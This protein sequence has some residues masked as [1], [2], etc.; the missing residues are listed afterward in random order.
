M[1]LFL[2][3]SPCDND[4]PAHM[5]L[6]CCYFTRN[7]FV[8]NLKKYWKQNSRCVIIAAN[9][10]NYEKSEEMVFTFRRCF[11]Y[12]GMIPETFVLLDSRNE[13]QAEELIKNSDFVML[14]GGHVPTERAFFERIG[15]REIMKNYDGLVMGISAGSMNA[16]DRVY[17]MPERPGEALDETFEKY[18]PGLG[19][20]KYNVIP[21]YDKE[22]DDFLDGKPLYTGWIYPDSM[23]ECYYVL[24]DGSYIL[25]VDGEAA[26]Y[27]KAYTLKDGELAVICQEEEKIILE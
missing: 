23:G 9:P 5:H 25:E 2:T 4:V 13:D 11:L 22:K 19:L 16:A 27:G 17:C 21:H 10:D 12:H 24:N 15:L 3:S 7:S 18:F 14:S 8:A 6:P 1:V 26:L 20:T